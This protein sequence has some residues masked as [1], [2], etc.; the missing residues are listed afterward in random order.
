MPIKCCATCGA[1][2]KAHQSKNRFCSRKCY[3][4][5]TKQRFAKTYTLQL[6]LSETQLAYIAGFFDAEGSIWKGPNPLPTTMSTRVSFYNT[7][8]HVLEVI[9]KWLG[10]G[11]IYEISPP[12]ANKKAC[13]N[14]FITVSV[15]SERLL[16][17]LL[18]YLH[19]K[20]LKTIEVLGTSK[21]QNPMSW[22]YIAGF[23]DGEGWA[24]YDKTSDVYRFG[25]TNKNR[26]VLEEIQRFIGFG[27]LYKRRRTANSDLLVAAYKQEL[28]FAEKI[29]PYAIVKR[30]VLEEASS[31]ILQR[32]WDVRKP[33]PRPKLGHV[34]DDELRYFYEEEGYSMNK[35]ARMY[36]VVEN[37]IW[38]RMKNAGVASRHNDAHQT[39]RFQLMETEAKEAEKE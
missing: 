3:D 29:L 39:F 38:L 17:V 5:F 14:L 24:T 35:L 16:S 2:F 18:P 26:Q 25:M 27:N 6:S 36:G 32:V 1:E 12:S 22:P 30:Q 28:Q 20:R 10:F 33:Y 23:F 37:A 11:A 13:F 9:Q 4:V 34:S 19:V 21:P 31:F 8:H 15:Y 7:N